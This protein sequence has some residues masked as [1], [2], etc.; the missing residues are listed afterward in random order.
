M[1]IKLPIPD[2]YFTQIKSMIYQVS[3]EAIENA[4]SSASLN[5]RY[6][7]KAET[8]EYLSCSYVTLQNMIDNLGLPLI[9]INNK[10]YIDLK[11]LHEFMNKFK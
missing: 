8:Q 3:L 1:D 10:H 6:L 11:D 2:E 5:K 4:K 7:T 9:K